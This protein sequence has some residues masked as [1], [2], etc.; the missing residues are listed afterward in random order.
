MNVDIFALWKIK[1]MEGV[2]VIKSLEGIRRYTCHLKWM[3]SS[4]AA[5]DIKVF[6][7]SSKVYEERRFVPWKQPREY[8]WRF[9]DR[10]QYT[11]VSRYF[12]KRQ[13]NLCRKIFGKIHSILILD[14]DCY[15][16]IRNISI[17]TGAEKRDGKCLELENCSNFVITNCKLSCQSDTTDLS[18]YPSRYK[19]GNES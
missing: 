9:R 12:L 7:Y 4:S 11:P 3:E 1:L 16:S 10:R 19:R 13:Y 6:N 18:P 17:E 15:V 14:P 8:W 5:A 2:D